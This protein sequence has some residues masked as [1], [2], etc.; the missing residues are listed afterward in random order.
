MPRLH[1]GAAIDR[2]ETKEIPKLSPIPEIVLLQPTETITEK[3]K[4][5]LY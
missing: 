2:P 4:L 3:S 1:S 5:K